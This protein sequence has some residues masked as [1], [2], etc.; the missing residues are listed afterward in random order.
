MVMREPL[1]KRRRR[2]AVADLPRLLGGRLCLDFV[3]SVERRLSPEPIDFLVSSVRLA[4]W[5]VHTGLEGQADPTE[6]ELQRCLVLRRALYDTFVGH[7]DE[8]GVGNA[9]SIVKSEA[10]AAMARGTVKYVDGRFDLKPAVGAMHVG[11]AV[12]LDG[13]NLLINGPLDRLRQC[14]GCADCGWLFL[15]SSRAGRRRWCSMEG[16]GSR[17]KMRRQYNTVGG[18]PVDSVDL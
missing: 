5:A 12:A 18:Q 15:D 10:A 7:I 3:N 16:C 4:D 14:P 17:V 11:D 1:N 2:G 6:A 8:V 13:W 9:A